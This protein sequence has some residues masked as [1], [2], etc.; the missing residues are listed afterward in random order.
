MEVLIPKPGV[1]YLLATPTY[2]DGTLSGP[3]HDSGDPWQVVP[4]SPSELSTFKQGLRIAE[5]TS[6]FHQKVDGKI[7][8]IPALKG[9][10]PT[11][12]FSSAGFP[13]YIVDIESRW[14][15]SVFRTYTTTSLNLLFTGEES[16]GSGDAKSLYHGYYTTRTGN[17]SYVN[18]YVHTPGSGAWGDIWRRNVNGLVISEIHKDYCRVRRGTL[19]GSGDTVPGE[20]SFESGLIVARNSAVHKLPTSD[21]YDANKYYMKEQDFSMSEIK[22]WI[23]KLVNP[24]LLTN[25]PSLNQDDWGDLAHE[26]SSNLDAN[27]ANMIAFVKD[28]RKVKDLIP[29]LKELGKIKTHASNYLGLEYGILPTVGDLKSIFEAFKQTKYMDRAG[30]RRV[31]AYAIR[32]SSYELLGELVPIQHTRRLHLAVNENDTGLD[33]LTEK[34]RSLGVFPSL[35]NIWDLVPYSF[36]LDWFVDVGSVLERID[37]HHRL[38]NLDIPY[39]IKSDKIEAFVSISN[40][41]IGVGAALTLTSYNREVTESVP[42]PRIFGEINKPP[43]VQNHWI[44]GSAL[45][46]SRKK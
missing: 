4:F 7:Y 6:V 24:A 32:T 34:V 27:S 40:A 43:T 29:Q 45:I 38:F 13:T 21:L 15:A 20:I 37:T 46:L 2:S 12:K 44:E 25:L 16:F 8:V 10:V 41:S 14:Y 30:Y 11:G 42:Q 36:V 18:N 19:P 9:A 22:T 1:W 5:E 33:S 39:V 28:L 3:Y 35:N 31:S 23:R 26:A 17:F